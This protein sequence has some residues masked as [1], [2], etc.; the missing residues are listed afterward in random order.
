MFLKSFIFQISYFF[1]NLISGLQIAEINIIYYFMI[2]KLNNTS[3][4]KLILL[5]IFK[6]IKR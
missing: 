6:I 5:F 3:K 2:K 1:I 4:K